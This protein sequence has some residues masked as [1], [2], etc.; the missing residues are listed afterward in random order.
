[1]R[2]QMFIS[3]VVLLAIV[4]AT[5]EQ[6]AQP[7]AAAVQGQKVWLGSYLREIGQRF[8]CYFT[9][10]Q[11]D[12][13]TPNILNERVMIEPGLK[14][15]ADVPGALSKRL[16]G[17]Q[18]LQCS[19]NPVVFRIVSAKSQANPEYWLDGRLDLEFQGPPDELLNKILYSAKGTSRQ[20]QFFIGNVPSAD[21]TTKVAVR[22]AGMPARSIMTN[23]LP[24]SRYSRVLWS[25][26]TTVLKE[27]RTEALLVD[28]QG[29]P[30]P[31]WTMTFAP[32]TQKVSVSW[33]GPFKSEYMP[34]TALV[35]FSEGE[36]ALYRN[37]KSPEAIAAAVD[38]IN[39]QMKT[40]NPF[41]VRWAMFY[42]G[43]HG[44]AEAVPLLLKY[45]A[46]RYTTCGVLEESYPAT[47]ALSMM[48]KPGSAAALKALGTETDGL[49]L[50]LLCR[51]VLLVEGQAQGAKTIEAEAA[52][53]ADAKQQQRIRDAL[54]SLA[55]PQAESQTPPAR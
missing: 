17:Y 3:A 41:Q 15:L 34:S 52:K 42:L 22:A 54:K 30:A 37:A 46:Y 31:G 23:F 16:E 35:P 11:W 1:M 53:V 18:V 28:R 43:K 4:P 47:L 55:E 49:R 32:G 26:T 48:G 7:P 29:V 25:A 5:A 9:I 24:L 20:S 14:Y 36:A 21:L 38:Y 33:G 10:H 40:E 13:G 8:D 44:V 39:A 27:G 6:P 51:V 12:Y 2:N 50:K 19:D 45:L